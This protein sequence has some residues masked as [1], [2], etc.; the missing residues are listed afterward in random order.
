MSTPVAA[1]TSQNV[2]LPY[3]PEL[4]DPDFLDLL[5]PLRPTP[6]VKAVT[7][8][9]QNAFMDAL[10]S[11]A[12][13]KFTEN[14]APAFSSTLS[15]TLDA[16]QALSPETPTENIH[17][18]LDR[19]WKEDPGLTLRLIWNARSIHDGKGDKEL[20]YRAFGWLYEHH[21]RTAIANLSQLVAPVCKSKGQQH[22]VPHGYWKD[23]LNILALATLE[24]FD[25]QPARF[26]HVPRGWQ[27]VDKSASGPPTLTT[28]E[29]AS[30]P[31]EEEFEALLASRNRKIKVIARERRTKLAAD[32]HAL[33]L[34]K[35]YEP[36]Y[37]ALYIVVARH[38]ADNLAEQTELVRQAEKIPAGG[39]RK[40]IFQKVSL[41]GKWAPT[42][43]ASHDRVTN[44]STALAILLR[45]DGAMVS[46]FRPVDASSE[47]PIDD[48]HVLRSFYQRWVLTPLRAA[49]RVPEPLMAARRW[50]AISYNHVPSKC[51][52]INSKHFLKHD[53][54]R[55][56]SFLDS[57]ADGKAKISGATLLPHELVN[58]ALASFYK[59]RA[60]SS[61]AETLQ[62][63]IAK[64][65]AQVV[66]AQWNAV[67]E[68]LR[69]AGTL[70]NCL[71]LCDVLGSMGN[72]EWPTARGLP[73]QPIVPAVALS[74]V[75]A[76]LAKP[77]FVNAFVTFSAQPQLV[78]VDPGAELA[79]R[80]WGM[81][82][83][84][85][86]M[87]TDLYG[88]FVNLLL[89]LAVKHT[90][91]RE[92]MVKRLFVFSD[93]QFDSA[94]WPQEAA[95]GV[96]K[97]ETTHNSIARA[98]EEAGYDMPEIVYWNLA[99]ALETAPAEAEHKGV[100]LMSGFSPA[101]MKVF[102][103]EE[104]DDTLDDDT[105]M[106]NEQGEEIKPA[107]K[108][109]MTPLSSMKHAL[110]MASYDGLEVVD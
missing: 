93:M 14:G 24:Q 99:G 26:L 16:F 9:P 27:Y 5:L 81:V 48:V 12:H 83:S 88:V 106:S 75:L 63:R 89:P 103:G 53:G 102:M 95:A 70:D 31:T 17:A 78:M 29:R 11:T 66:D 34:A 79:N 107:A 62:A 50:E 90:V 97:W 2:Y 71:A 58:K 41:V 23:L 44:I 35:L 42:P 105:V 86:G 68:R 33:L 85:W 19:A 64:R 77:P 55:F 36:R 52:H 37:R 65:E 59:Q 40:H 108:M 61:V 91:P 1:S 69:S 56:G 57:V 92:A 21:P 110:G 100:A 32:T 54:E 67:L 60:D 38:F 22:L 72:I 51:M 84:D 94:A 39:E 10:K 30:A 47:V 76:E 13:R 109:E 18:M 98:Y 4:F 45:H 25:A 7:P 87:N 101:M 46:L 8:E 82:N 28:A 73:P 15:D 74:M 20:F 96:T 3:I 43:G 80:V 104:D 6:D 49:S